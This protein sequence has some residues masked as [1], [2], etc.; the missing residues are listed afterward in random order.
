MP[1]RNIVPRNAAQVVA[2]GHISNS[3]GKAKGPLPLAEEPDLI[4]AIRRDMRAYGVAGEEKN[5][6]RLYFTASS[7]KLDRPL[8]ALLQGESTAGKSFLIASIAELM[9]PEEILRATRMTPQALYHLEEP[10][11]HKFVVGGERSRV[12]DDQFADA[13]AA[14]RQLRSEG[15]ITKQITQKNGQGFR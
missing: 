11:S 7:R 9:P 5:A 12:Q 1:T 6:M 15:R 2:N 8:S 13:T 10:I 3:N 14:L 4:A